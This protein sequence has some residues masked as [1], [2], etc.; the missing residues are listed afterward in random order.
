MYIVEASKKKKK[1]AVSNV[2]C[3]CAQSCPALCNPMECSLPGSS[4]H[5]IFQAEYWNGSPFPPPGYPPYPVIK[6]MSPV[7]PALAGR[8]ITTEPPMRAQ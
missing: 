5:G 8:F 3:V 6:P 2:G 1:M 4:V 7:S